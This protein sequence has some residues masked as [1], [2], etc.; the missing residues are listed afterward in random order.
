MMFRATQRDF[1]AVLR[2]V[3]TRKVRPV[4]LVSRGN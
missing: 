3:I 1:V 2:Y 4:V